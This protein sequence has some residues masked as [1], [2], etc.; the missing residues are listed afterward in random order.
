MRVCV[1]DNAGNKV[2][3]EA[4]HLEVNNRSILSWFEDFNKVTKELLEFK[5]TFEKRE[6]ELHKIWNKV[7]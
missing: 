7:R 3:I 4:K 6:I 2:E 5:S 1:I